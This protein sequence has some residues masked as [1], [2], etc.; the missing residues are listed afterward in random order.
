MIHALI[1]VIDAGL[2]E[3]LCLLETSLVVTQPLIHCCNGNRVNQ[4]P[5]EQCVT[6]TSLDDPCLVM[7]L[8]SGKILL[9]KVLQ[10]LLVIFLSAY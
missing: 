10:G 5:H 6:V 1:G 2:P 9:P 3:L 4:Q 7:I 8:G